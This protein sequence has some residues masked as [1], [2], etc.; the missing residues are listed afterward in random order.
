MSSSDDEVEA[1]PHT[2]SNYHF[3]DEKD[4]P[5]AFSQLP[6]QW[7][8]NESLD[9]MNK[10][11]FL[12]G[13]ADN[14]LQKIYK[15]VT[16]WKFDLSNAEPEISVLSKENSWMKLH[17][18]RKSFEDV[19]R[20]ILITVHCLHFVKKDPESSGKALW[21][22]LSKV[23]SLYEI[24]PSQNDLVDHMDLISEAV[25]RDETLGKSKFLVTFLEEKP[26]KSKAFEEDAVTT[27][28][29]EF[30]VD[31]DMI[32]EPDEDGSDDDDAGDLFDS[33]CSICDNG[34]ELLCCEGRC[35]RSFH[36]TK[37]AGS[38]SMCESLGLSD[39]QVEAIQNFF[40]KNCQHK[41]HQCYSCGYLGSSDKLSG[42]EVFPCVSA[43][44]GRFYH[45]SC[46]AKLLHRESV[47]EAEKLQRKI[48]SGETFTCPV[49]KCCVCKQGE[50]KMDPDLQFAICRR[51]PKS[52]HR[53]C[54]PRMISFEDV[55]EE[56]IVQRA[57]EGLMPNRILIYCLKHEIDDE[58]ATP[59]RNHIK[60]PFDDRQKKK[61]VSELPS[62]REQV[63]PKRRS[64]AL[65][66]T[67][68]KRTVV[69]PPKLS[70]ALKQG[71]SL[72]KNDGR[73]SGSSSSKKLKVMDTSRKTLTKTSSFK[74]NKSN[75]DESK[76]SLGDRLY[77][78]MNKDSDPDKTRKEDITSS[79]HEETQS[80][81]PPATE[82]RSLP[83][84]DADAKRR[85][86]ALMKDAASSITLEQVIKKHK[87][88]ITHA[89][90][91]RSAVDKTITLGKVEGSVEALRTALQKLEEGCSIED[92]KA[93]CE[94]G[95]LNQI[96]RWKNKLKVYL[97][98]FLYGMRYTSFGRHF[99]KV[100]KLKEIVDK[101]HWYVQEGDMIVDFCCGSND[102]SCLMKEKLD[103][104]GKN[105][106][107]K[108]YD[109]LQAK[110]DF[111]FEKRDWMSVRQK[112]LPAGSQLIMGLNPPFGVNAA[113][114]NK[115]I[116]KALEFKPKLLILIVPR[117][118]ERLD[119]KE[120]PYDLVWEDDELL[121]G[122][123]F[124]LP[125]SV[126]VY[127]KQLEDWNVNAPPLYL[128]SRPDWTA[129]HKA[130]AQQCGH[131]SKLREKLSLEE[132]GFETRV[133]DLTVEGHDLNG[134][135][136][137][138]VDDHH[139]PD[140]QAHLQERGASLTESPND[141][142]RHGNSGME[143][144]ENHGHGQNLSTKNSK[145]RHRGE[146]KRERGSGKMS[147]DDQNGQ[148]SQ[149]RH[150]PPSIAGDKSLDS[151]SSKLLEI[152]SHK[153]AGE[154]SYGHFERKSISGSHS[155][156]RMGYG[157]SDED[158]ARSYGFNS[159]EPYSTLTQ[160][161]SYGASPGPDYG[162]RKSEEQLK[163]HQRASTDSLG[164]RSYFT[165]MEEKYG[166]ESDIRSQVR[167]YGQQDLDLL[168]GRE[169]DIRS[170][171]RLYGQQDPDFSSQRD[172]YIAAGHNPV[173]SS[174]YGHI[175]LAGDPSYSRAHT[176][177]MQRYAPRLDELNPARVNSLGSQP[178]LLS[179]SG[180]YDPPPPRP[181]FRADSLGF[182]PGPYLPFSQQN[183]SGWLN[184]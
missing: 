37:E 95:L 21:D 17:K 96:M 108:N 68:G 126:D 51:C 4:E 40:C 86:L 93:V 49:H 88:P 124:Y 70:S 184:E 128:W 29:S 130:I 66:D 162:I 36:A 120:S 46:V 7:I 179:R 12:H 106:T 117:E 129:K 58:L 148:R 25:K 3:V 39:E 109:V 41:Q 22:R 80:V 56:G 110:S 155:Q 87:V 63:A 75:T 133:S 62:S 145:K 26:K 136:P 89:Y 112:E 50:N 24:K 28:K 72:K 54:L 34:G 153:D 151:Q 77:A 33:V 172:S 116:N 8:E 180:M 103:E 167:L 38:D 152:L 118:T 85:I 125:G 149:P 52:Y 32:D 60:F 45:P 42:A 141:G 92:A 166:R 82:A 91:S 139:V 59:V 35:M 144:H 79:E 173:F 119:K 47:A 84:L 102:F 114:A 111:N 164:Y 65:D 170:H 157:N 19:I 48:A 115:F 174:S 171:V 134:G 121:V 78:L 57:W 9:G 131:L 100:D 53:K 154:Q 122:K 14:G 138:L 113:L 97:A 18:P 23:F 2:V 1:L 143:G 176:S 20:T 150:S 123:S 71:D 90:S 178:P 182:A 64:L 43:T 44:C 158:M 99:T 142:F 177:T 107:Y 156:F 69:K 181:G 165:E 27:V 83:P 61:Q 73:L 137:M 135:T 132:N 31:D 13:T 11:I 169:S 163:D 76:T 55:E 127:D 67:F 104:M 81:E 168:N 10:Q 101:L 30:I 161:L 15:Q 146:R 160:R 98:P 16:A 140:E 159:E 6:V 94:P 175:G 147:Q 105:C 183:S 5:I 74:V